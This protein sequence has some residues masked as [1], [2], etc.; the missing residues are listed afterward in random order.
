MQ[1]PKSRIEEVYALSIQQLV[2]TITK[3]FRQD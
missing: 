3:V 2:F 1:K